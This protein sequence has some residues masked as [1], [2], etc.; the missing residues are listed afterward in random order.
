MSLKVFCSY[1]HNDEPL[2]NEL[3]KYL[4]MLERQGVISTWCDRSWLIESALA[5][6]Q[7]S[8]GKLTVGV[9]SRREGIVT[10]S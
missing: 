8:V 6:A 5:F 9:A 1:S 2:K 3:A 10:I 4:T 7:R